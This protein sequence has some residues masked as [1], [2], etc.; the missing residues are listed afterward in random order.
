MKLTVVLNQENK[1]KNRLYLGNRLVA[2]G[3]NGLEDVTITTKGKRMVAV[4]ALT[5]FDVIVESEN[6]PELF[7]YSEIRAAKGNSE[8]LSRLGYTCELLE[9]S[10]VACDG[11]PKNPDRIKIG[12]NL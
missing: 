5:V 7:H 1:Y 3:D 9:M 2:S 6:C 4:V 11:C 12:G 10:S 8:A